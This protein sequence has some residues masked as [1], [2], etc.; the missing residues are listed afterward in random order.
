M[1]ST[2]PLTAIIERMKEKL[3]KENPAILKKPK[4]PKCPKP[5]RKRSRRSLSSL[6]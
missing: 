2:N 4:E 5:K 3:V 6:H 1:A